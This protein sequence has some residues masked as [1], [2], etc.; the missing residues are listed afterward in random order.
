[1]CNNNVKLYKHKENA[2]M[3]KH[4]NIYLSEEEN[5]M[6]VNE[7]TVYEANAVTPDGLTV[8]LRKFKEDPNGYLNRK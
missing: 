4:K 7:E 2:K 3:K 8:P 5:A 6:I 1:M